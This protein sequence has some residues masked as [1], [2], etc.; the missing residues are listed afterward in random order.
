MKSLTKW[1]VA[2]AAVTVA[3]VGAS[4]QVLQADVPFAFGGVA[5]R[6]SPGTYQVTIDSNH[7]VHFRNMDTHDTR[8][9]TPA[10]LSDPKK[11]WRASAL[12]K[13]VFQCGPSGCEIVGLWAGGDNPALNFR[14][15]AHDDTKIAMIPLR[16]VAR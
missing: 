4:A 15:K 8:L 1:M 3:A 12:P 16:V 14:S 7:L 13:M 6:E 10:F 5:G 11:E 2:A 9:A